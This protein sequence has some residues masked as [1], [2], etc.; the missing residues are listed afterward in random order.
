MGKC[1]IEVSKGHGADMQVVCVH[2]KFL[3]RKIGL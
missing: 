3:F 1:Y 2:E